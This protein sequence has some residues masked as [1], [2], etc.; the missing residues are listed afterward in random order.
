MS[1]SALAFCAAFLASVV[2]AAPPA[3]TTAAAAASGI[4]TAP[5]LTESLSANNQSYVIGVISFVL[6]AV[7]TILAV[8]SLTSVDYSNDTLLTVDVDSTVA[9]E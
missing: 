4:Y 1:N 2:L 7:C 9:E 8:T 3:T 6:F 5:G